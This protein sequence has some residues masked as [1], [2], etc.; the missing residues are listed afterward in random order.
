MPSLN[1]LSTSHDL[2]TGAVRTA[3]PSVALGPRRLRGRL[4]EAEV[5][6]RIVF[7]LPDTV[8]PYPESGIRESAYDVDSVGRLVTRVDM[9]LPYDGPNAPRLTT[10]DRIEIASAVVRHF[11]SGTSRS[12]VAFCVN[13]RD[14]DLAETVA[15]ALNS[16]G[17]AVRSAARCPRTYTTGFAPQDSSEVAPH[18]YIDPIVIVQPEARPWA[19]GVVLLLNL[20]VSQG[21]VTSVYECEV[22]Q[23]RSGWTRVSC[24][25]TGRRIS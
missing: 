6:E 17:Q 16:A 9:V 24:I 15:A 21:T 5:E 8:A 2:F 18:G 1:V 12:P 4:V 13:L 23:V 7:R 14:P 25:S 11:V 3:L 19:R 22:E 20:L 10:R